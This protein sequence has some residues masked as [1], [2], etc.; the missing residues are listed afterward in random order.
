MAGVADLRLSLTDEGSIK[1]HEHIY[2]QLL[3]GP[4]HVFCKYI[5]EQDRRVGNEGQKSQV[6][7]ANKINSG[8]RLAGFFVG[9]P[10]QKFFFLPAH[11]N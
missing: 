4:G 5:H 7:A 3:Q 6:T 1:I 9:W 8:L 11:I 2:C 10:C